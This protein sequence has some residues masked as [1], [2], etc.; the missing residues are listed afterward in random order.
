MRY[1]SFSPSPP[2]IFS[3]HVLTHFFSFQVG[4]GNIVLAFESCAGALCYCAE[5]Q[6]KL[7]A[8][9]N[10]E[11]A[12][13]LRSATEAASVSASSRRRNGDGGGDGGHEER[14]M[15]NR[16]LAD[17]KFFCMSFQDISKVKMKMGLATVSPRQA[18]D[19][20]EGIDYSSGKRRYS[21]PVLN[22]ASRVAKSAHPGQILAVGNLAADLQGYG[23]NP[24]ATHGGDDD[25]TAAPFAKELSCLEMRGMGYYTLKGFGLRPYYLTDVRR[26]DILSVASS[27]DFPDLEDTT[28]ITK[29]ASDTVHELQ[30]VGSS[31][32][33]MTGSGLLKKS[34]HGGSRFAIPL[35]GRESRGSRKRGGSSH[36]G[37]SGP[38]GAFAG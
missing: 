34:S 30:T 24:A 20:F 12:K 38:I 5:I 37:F 11:W 29:A 36:G 35:E 32:E 27:L 19:V 2:L 21:T 26:S 8:W 22:M 15:R 4:V 3:H 28:Y 10:G 31:K 1:E 25:P 18:L 33:K 23:L 7:E 17:E 14:L 13:A 9:E 6:R 16:E